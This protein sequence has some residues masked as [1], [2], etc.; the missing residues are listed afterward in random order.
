MAIAAAMIT[1][2]ATRTIQCFFLFGLKELFL[3]G[4]AGDGGVKVVEASEKREKRLSS[5]S[6]T[7]AR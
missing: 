3:D 7:G 5:F 2:M 4:A 6:P 1:M